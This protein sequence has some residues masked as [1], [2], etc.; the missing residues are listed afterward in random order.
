MSSMSAPGPGRVKTEGTEID[1][2]AARGGCGSNW[3]CG[4]GSNV[5][6]EGLS[7][8]SQFH[9]QL[10]S[11]N[12]QEPLEVISK[13]MQAHFRSDLIKRLCQEMRGTHP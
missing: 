2:L 5:I 8:P 4:N 9:H 13:H 3:L 10:C 11:H 1:G 7:D 12:A 6:P